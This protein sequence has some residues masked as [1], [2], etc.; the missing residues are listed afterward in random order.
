MSNNFFDSVEDDL[1]QQATID[2]ERENKYDPKEGDT[3]QGV[4]LKAE[5][6]TQGKYKATVSVTFR[7]VGEEEV[8]G[9]AAGDSAYFMTPTVLRRK[10]IEAEPK[11]GTAFMLR[12]LGSVKPEGGG[13]SYKDWVLV[14]ESTK[15]EDASKRDVG[16]WSSI[17]QTMAQADNQG[18]RQQ[19]QQNQGQPA[20][21]SGWQF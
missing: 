7:N 1:D 9:V 21:S 10:F 16:L 20:E 2:Q 17:V 13:N 3:L 19:P 4:I 11:I 8:G 6:F 14:T 18:G 12:F 15:D 5:A